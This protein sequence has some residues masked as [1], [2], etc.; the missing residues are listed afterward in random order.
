[1]ADLSPSGEGL[2]FGLPGATNEW[3]KADLTFTVRYWKTLINASFTEASSS[4][5]ASILSLVQDDDCIEVFFPDRFSPNDLYGGGA[6]FGSGTATAQIVASD[7]NAVHG[8]DRTHFAH[9]LGHV[10][11]LHH[12]G[13]GYPTPARP[14][15]IDGSSGTLLCPSGFM[16]DNPTVNSQENK[17]NLHNPLIRFKFK[18]R[19]TGPDCAD[20]LECGACP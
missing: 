15:V 13:A 12:P 3:A 5:M 11:G 4:E 9:E 20:S 19:T 18:V 6:T 8:I 17:E 1:L 2:A 7:E 10:V 14:E 16:N